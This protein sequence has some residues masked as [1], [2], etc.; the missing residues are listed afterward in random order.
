MAFT[1][2]DVVTLA[3]FPLALAVAGAAI[4]GGDAARGWVIALA[5]AAA[6]TDVVDGW[7]ARRS[8]TASARGAALD[9]W[10]DAALAVAL[11]IALVR[12]VP[13]SEWR[14]WIVLWVAAIIVIRV[15]VAVMARVRGEPAIGHTVLNKA[16]GVAA[17]VAVIW[18]LAAGA[19]PPVATAVALAI[20]TLAALAE[21]ASGRQA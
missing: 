6:L 3:R 16:A 11:T 17:F 20:A 8:G 5:V 21:G 18:A 13:A 4:A 10:A 2:A 15:I 9:S 14:P 7:L 19:F 12:L 1:S